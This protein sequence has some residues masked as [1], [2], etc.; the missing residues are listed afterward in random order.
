MF[1]GVLFGLTFG[2]RAVRMLKSRDLGLR[3]IR[4]RMNAP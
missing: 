4:P 3:M 2:N 1:V